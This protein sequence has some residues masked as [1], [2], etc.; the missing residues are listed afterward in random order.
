M[1]CVW[2]GK[3]LTTANLD[4]D[5][6][7][8]WSA[9]PCSDLWNLLPVRREVNSRK[10]ARLPDAVTLQSAAER[11]IEWWHEGY[12]QAENP[13]VGERFVREAR[14]EER[15]VGKGGRV[16]WWRD[17]S[18]RSGRHCKYQGGNS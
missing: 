16:G 14:S 5:H 12:R 3:R 15:R 6:C 2:S 18:R 9:W 8:P 10:G 11:I 7:F 4:I 1:R 13:R 17:E